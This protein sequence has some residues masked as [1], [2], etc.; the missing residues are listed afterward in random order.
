MRKMTNTD[1]K[2]PPPELV[3][4][5]WLFA[6]G[7]SDRSIAMYGQAEYTRGVQDAIVVAVEAAGANQSQGQIIN[8][9]RALL[10]AKGE[11]KP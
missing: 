11:P 6:Y 10:T 9:I 4:R 7:R 3:A 8:A 2:A 5:D 1:P